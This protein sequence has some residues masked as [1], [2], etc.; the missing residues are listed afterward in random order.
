MR[1]IH[2]CPLDNIIWDRITSGT[3]AVTP[4]GVAP[5]SSLNDEH[6]RRVT[7][8]C[9]K[10]EHVHY[11]TSDSRARTAQAGLLMPPSQPR[12]SMIRRHEPLGFKDVLPH[13]PPNLNPDRSLDRPLSLCTGYGH[14][15]DLGTM[16]WPRHRGGTDSEIL[17][18]IHAATFL[19]ST[20]SDALAL[21]HE[22]TRLMTL[23]VISSSHFSTGRTPAVSQS[24]PHAHSHVASQLLEYTCC[25]S[26]VATAHSTVGGCWCGAVFSAFGSL[27]CHV[28]SPPLPRCNAVCVPS[29]PGCMSPNPSE[30]ESLFRQVGC[31][32]GSLHEIITCYSLSI[33][34][35]SL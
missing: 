32:T 30:S 29:K 12:G 13:S 2:G 18:I 8:Y 3:A 27:R 11:H 21:P 14:G 22:L 28:A 5:V 20:P 26:D 16:S 33:S 1:L 4:V 34:T 23:C 9:R 25:W 7:C 35:R 15:G 10:S 19:P 24:Q 17:D 6:P 31:I